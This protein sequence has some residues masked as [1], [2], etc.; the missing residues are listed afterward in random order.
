LGV[1]PVVPPVPGVLVSPLRFVASTDPVQAQS[2]GTAAKRASAY[3]IEL[4][5]NLRK[6]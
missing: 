3:F 6:T 1:V 2:M 4:M 5:R